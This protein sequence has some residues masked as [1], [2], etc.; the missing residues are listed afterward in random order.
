MTGCLAASAFAGNVAGRPEFLKKDTGIEL[1][2]SAAFG[3]GSGA[4]QRCLDVVEALN[5]GGYVDSFG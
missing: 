2:D 1:D 4:R 3:P 5:D